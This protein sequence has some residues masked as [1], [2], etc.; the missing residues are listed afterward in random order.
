MADFIPKIAKYRGLLSQL[1]K[2]EPPP[3]NQAHTAVVHHLKHLLEKLTHLQILV[4]GHRL[5]QTDA[6]KIQWGTVFF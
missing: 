4:N 3:W 1:L 2:K 6:N 5:L